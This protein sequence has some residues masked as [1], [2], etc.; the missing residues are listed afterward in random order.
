MPWAMMHR[1][2][3]PAPVPRNRSLM[4]L[5]R[6]DLAVDEVFAFAGAI[7][8]AGDLHFLGVGGELAL[9]VVEGHGD[10]G[11]P[12][13]AARSGAV[14]DDVGHFAAAQAFGGLLAENPADGIDDVALARAVRPDDGGDAVA[15]LEDGL[16]G[17]ALEADEFEAFEH[18]LRP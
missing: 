10:F 17:K 11:Q 5:S 6:A 16:V 8:A 7:D 3:L 18:D 1:S 9:A 4:S 14:E 12:E 13:A 2:S 15:E